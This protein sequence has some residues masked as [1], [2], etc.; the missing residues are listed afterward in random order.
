M[1]KDGNGS[2]TGYL[3]ENVAVEVQRCPLVVRDLPDFARR[4]LTAADSDES[5][6]YTYKYS[7]NRRIGAIPTRT[8]KPSSVPTK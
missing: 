7:A 5:S 6:V 3:G 2:Q 8:M 1:V 4:S